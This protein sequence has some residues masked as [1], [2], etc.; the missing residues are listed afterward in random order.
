MTDTS[1]LAPPSPQIPSL[2]FGWV[3]YLHL[4]LLLAAFGGMAMLIA[5]AQFIRIQVTAPATGV[6]TLRDTISLRSP[7]S[8]IVD[9]VMV[10]EGDTIAAGEA[11]LHLRSDDLRRHL[12][13]L[14]ADLSSQVRQKA[15]VNAE[16]EAQRRVRTMIVTERQQRMDLATAELERI[17]EIQSIH[18]E[19]QMAGWRRRP[20]EQLIPVRRAAEAVRMARTH[21]REAVIEVESLEARQSEL[22]WLDAQ[23]QRL[24]AQRSQLFERLA[25]HTLRAEKGGIIRTLDPGHLAGSAVV[26]GQVVVEMSTSLDWLARLSV[27]E[28]EWSKIRV[29]QRAQLFVDAYPHVQH[30]AIQAT[31]QSVSSRPAPG[32]GSGYPVRLRIDGADVH[33]LVLAQGMK[34]NA[35]ITVD[36]GSIIDLLADWFQRQFR[37]AR[38][39]QSRMN[40][41]GGTD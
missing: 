29:G 38:R 21:L 5:A 36:E 10:G 39:L 31:V 12:R 4:W 41:I 16:I 19:G 8:A 20:L 9:E 3:S 32:T 34:V 24:L 35:Q 40:F 13:L 17:R 25:Q 28:G 18:S 11:V 23:R 1:I 33:H 14:E 6:L 37:H 7:L 26:A 2:G 30:G 27:H 15:A 22:D